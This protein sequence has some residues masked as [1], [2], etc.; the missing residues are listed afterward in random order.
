MKKNPWAMSSEQAFMATMTDFGSEAKG[1]F[2]MFL[3][4]H[5]DEDVRR[6]VEARDLTA[7]TIA[8]SING[9]L[10]D[11]KAH[12]ATGNCR[13]CL[14]CVEDFDYVERFTP[15]AFVVWLP[16]SVTTV[17][18]QHTIACPVCVEC[19]Q[20]YDDETIMAE[21]MKHCRV[22]APDAQV[23]ATIGGDDDA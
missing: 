23:V 21:A 6:A 5:N 14:M 10:I 8:G 4:R 9:A 18:P 22:L 15:A 3:V 13:A 17:T 12:A 2:R 11:I 7:C 20:D 16:K 1:L 19:E